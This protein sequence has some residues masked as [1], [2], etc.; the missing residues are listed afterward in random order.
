MDVEHE[1]ETKPLATLSPFSYI[2]PRRKELKEM[3]YF[4]RD[5]QVSWDQL[6]LSTLAVRLASLPLLLYL[7]SLGS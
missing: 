4:N 2:P 5:S 7:F 1:A 6:H 3:S